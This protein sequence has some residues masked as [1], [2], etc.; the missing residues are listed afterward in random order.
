MFGLTFWLTTFG[1]KLYGSLVFAWSLPALNS[2]LP[3][4]PSWCDQVTLAESNQQRSESDPHNK[5]YLVDWM[6]I[7][8]ADGGSK[9]L[10]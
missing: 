8:V 9:V 7:P 1:V 2:P 3:R 6:L 4:L 5:L 10:V